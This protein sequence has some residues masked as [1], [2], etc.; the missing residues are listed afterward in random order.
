MMAMALPR[1]SGADTA[2]LERDYIYRR[3]D[4]EHSVAE[5]VEDGAGFV[6]RLTL[7]VDTRR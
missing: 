2:P 3:Q 5:L 6:A 4:G 7:V 1:R